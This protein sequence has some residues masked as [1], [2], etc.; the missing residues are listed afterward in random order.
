MRV[1]DIRGSGRLTSIEIVE[2]RETKTPTFAW[3]KY[4]R[5]RAYK[6]GLYVDIGR[7]KDKLYNR[8]NVAH[9]NT[10]PGFQF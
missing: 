7:P 2:D 1:G 8:R 4:V 6:I 9:L 10:N 5:D 3:G